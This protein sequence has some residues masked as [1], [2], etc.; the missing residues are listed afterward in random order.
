MNKSSPSD[1][2]A[3]FVRVV[4][5]GSF[6]AAAA[7]TG[8]TP[9]GVSKVVSRL[10][11]RLGVRLLQRTTRRLAITQEG[12]TMLARGRDVL[13]A[14]E[15]LEAEVTA[16]RGKPRGRV[17]VNTGTAY[18]KHCLIPALPAF[19]ARFPEIEIE[20][21]IDDRRIDVIGQQ[22]DLA[23]R[24]GPLGDTTLIARKL[25]EGTRMICASRAYLRRCGKPRSPTDLELHSC[26]RMTGNAQ[27]AEWE[28]RSANGVVPF[29]VKSWIT[30]DSVDLMYD[31]VRHGVGIARW[32]SFLVR[33]DLKA[34]SLVALM[35]EHHV[36]EPFAITALMPPGRQHLPR[37][38][39]LVDYLC[40][41]CG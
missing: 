14:I 28:M 35:L 6:A 37:V 27:L 32:P 24:T 10:E 30:V 26:L 19:H 15:A 21:G 25:G 20:L 18:A 16:S 29:K 3:L 40:K 36:A 9:S 8:L 5:R 13:A 38:R 41:N 33:D 34:G 39:A 23:I 31:M 11:D 12:E 4:E 17:R 7:E 2:I 22:V 1:E